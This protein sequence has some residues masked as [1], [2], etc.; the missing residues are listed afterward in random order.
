LYA[1][2]DDL[3]GDLRGDLRRILDLG[4]ASGDDFARELLEIVFLAMGAPIIPCMGGGV[5]GAV[6]LC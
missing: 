2:D 3:L 1:A 4:Q 6:F 5:A